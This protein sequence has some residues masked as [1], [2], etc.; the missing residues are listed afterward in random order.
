MLSKKAVTAKPYGQ[1]IY[2]SIYL[3][4][5]F[6]NCGPLTKHGSIIAVTSQLKTSHFQDLFNSTCTFKNWCIKLFIDNRFLMELSQKWKK[7]YI[8]VLDINVWP[9]LL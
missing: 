3:G 7:F 8:S 9:Q 5:D 4:M 2:F 6:C 1:P